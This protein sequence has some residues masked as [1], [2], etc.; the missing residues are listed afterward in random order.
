MFFFLCFSIQVQADPTSN[1]VDLNQVPIKDSSFQQN[2]GA[3][4][5]DGWEHTQALSS[6]ALTVQKAMGWALGFF[7][8]QWTERQSTFVKRQLVRVTFSFVK[9]SLVKRDFLVIT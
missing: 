7:S 8:A 1:Y 4:K 5:R 9:L 3:V 2:F 6:W